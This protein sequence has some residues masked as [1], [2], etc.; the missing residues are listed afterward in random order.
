MIK[1]VNNVAPRGRHTLHLDERRRRR[2]RR[3]KTEED[4]EDEG[5]GGSYCATANHTTCLG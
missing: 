1:H 3:K 4:E 2:R 5:K